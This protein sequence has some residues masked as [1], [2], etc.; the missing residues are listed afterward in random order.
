M[1]SKLIG[2]SPGCRIPFDK[3]HPQMY[4]SELVGTAL[5]VFLGLSIV[6]A[7]WGR[8]A[9]FAS[10]PIPTDARR[11]LNG[12]LFGRV[13]AAIAYSPIGRMSGAHINPAMTF[14]FWLEGKLRWRDA[15]CYVFAQLIG[16]G[17]GAAALL[18]WGSVGA[19]DEWG[20]SLPDRF[21]PE[22]ASDCGR[23][24]LHFL[25]RS[26]DFYFRSSQGDPTLYATGEPAALCGV[27]MAGGAA[28]RRERESGPLLRTRIDRL[29]LARLVGLLDWAVPWRGARGRRITLRH[30]SSSSPPRSAHVPFRPS[31]GDGA[32]T[33]GAKKSGV[34]TP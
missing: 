30:I 12:F 21:V 27:D 22:L 31:R 3:L 8:G 10:L 2:R 33:H 19:S 13:G 26:V 7:L 14:A 17:F 23:N 28:L 29:G 11:L 16:A 24:G 20:A 4:A 32:E 15:S 6:I 9:P 5:L 18:L 1:R 25:A 34:S